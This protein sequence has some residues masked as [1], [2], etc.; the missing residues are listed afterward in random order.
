MFIPEKAEY[1]KSLTA[2][3]AIP[4]GRRSGLVRYESSEI[5]MNNN[6]RS[7]DDSQQIIAI[8]GCDTIVLKSGVKYVGKV[9]EIGLTEVKYRRCTNLTGPVISVLNSDVNVIKYSNGTND[10]FTSNDYIPS[11]VVTNFNNSQPD[12]R[13]NQGLGVAG[14]VTSLTGLFIFS[15]PLGVLSVIFGAVSLGKIKRERRFKG[16]GFAIAAIIIGLVDIIAMILLLGS[17]AAV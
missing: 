10:Y 2:S 14:F 6:A 12:V 4:E 5:F 3:V 7:A 11:A 17:V 8:Q 9:E 15:I 1:R 16:R 13:K